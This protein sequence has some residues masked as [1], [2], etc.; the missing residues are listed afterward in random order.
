MLESVLARVGAVPR[1]VVKTYDGSHLIGRSEARPGDSPGG[2]EFLLVEHAVEGGVEV[3]LSACLT[4]RE[5][6]GCSVGLEIEF[7][8]WST[9]NYVTM[10]AAVYAGNRFES[11]PLDYPPLIDSPL[12]FA[13]DAPTRIT[14]VPRLNVDQ[15]Y[16]RIQL[17]AGDMAT[18]A[19]GV[20]LAERCA[21]AWLVSEQGSSHGDVGLAIEESGDRTR[22]VI[23]VMAPGVRE[24]VRY[25]YWATQCPSA[26]RGADLAAGD[27]VEFRFG[28]Y[29][30]DCAD[31]PAFF[32]RFVE[33]RKSLSGAVA[34]KHELPFSAAWEIEQAKYNRENWDAERGYYRVGI[35]RTDCAKWQLGW[36]GGAQVTHPL[37]AEGGKLSTER[38]MR[39]LE[40]L[41]L[42]T[43]APSG[44]FHGMGD[45]E[46]FYGDGFDSPH[47]FNMSLVRKNSDVLYFIY[48]Q[49]DLLEKHGIAIPQSWNDSA[50]RQ[51]DAFVQLWRKYGQFGQFVDIE[52]GDIVVGGSTSASM[53]PAGL[54]LASA[55]FDDI[56]YLSVARESA[57]MMYRRDVLS[58]VTTGGPGE[59]LQCPDSESGFG[60][61]ESFVVLYE[62]TLEPRWLEM[63]ED[64]AN[65]CASWVHSY[66]FRFPPDSLFGRLDMRTSGA[67]WANVQNKH[68]APA[69]C[70]L[71]GDSLFKLWRATENERYLDLIRDIAHNIPQYLSRAD[72]RVGGMPEGYMS[73]RVNTSDWLEGVGEIFA[74]SCW[75]EVSLMMAWAE[76][77]G[78]YVQPD[79]GFACA[80]DHVEIIGVEHSAKGVTLQ[81]YNPTSFDACVK[82]MVE[83]S[84]RVA[85]PMGQNAMLACKVVEIPGGGVVEMQCLESTRVHEP[86]KARLM[87]DEARE[88]GSVRLNA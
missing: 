21:A 54:A 61:L 34:L 30:F 71:S 14:D 38:A 60:L 36:L 68:A 15:G 55:Y 13:V 1:V 59:I 9:H 31:I 79:T 83:D 49:F 40:M 42:R 39:N 32:D 80:I 66:D 7:A 62:T 8:D 22:S 23:S 77:P 26:D 35:G 86:C 20:R 41:F 53:A 85:T 19:V 87:P 64:M 29:V 16:S 24:D 84:T 69:I 52:T 45:G 18:P 5:A 25:H 88:P 37:L 28:L 2:W 11:R 27:S 57:E 81:I 78:V 70:T 50:R 12:D 48:K 47:P 46:R 75:C 73:E 56:Q 63:A 58:G 44:F 76:L 82:V 3:D 10:P 17:L 33:I 51:A 4:A 74:G 72:K 67:V 6:T 43:Q 65:Q